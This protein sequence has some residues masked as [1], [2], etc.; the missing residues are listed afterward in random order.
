MIFLA[1]FLRLC[2]FFL[3]I[4]FRFFPLSALFFLFHFHRR[5]YLFSWIESNFSFSLWNYGKFFLFPIYLS[6]L[7][8]GF[9]LRHK[10]FIVGNNGKVFIKQLRHHIN[11]TSSI[12][13]DMILLK[14]FS[15]IVR[16]SYLV[17]F[18][19]PVHHRHRYFNP[20]LQSEA[21]ARAR[22]LVGE[23][24]FLYFS[25]QPEKRRKK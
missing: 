16:C 12:V 2:F 18:H 24:S 21:K 5:N 19:H 1:I 13:Y 6:A 11:E 7:S 8:D 4:C 14:T 25:K 10:H 17:V 3:N 23:Y 20:N 15:S 22:R 9:W